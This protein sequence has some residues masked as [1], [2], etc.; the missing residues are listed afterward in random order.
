MQ[1][2]EYE[3]LL[4][5]HPVECFQRKHIYDCIIIKKQRKMQGMIFKN[6]FRSPLK[7][8]EL[9]LKINENLCSEQHRKDVDYVFLVH[10]RIQA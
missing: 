9:T 2:F 5:K 3:S 10:T 7:S 6:L 4:R 8:S 1:Q